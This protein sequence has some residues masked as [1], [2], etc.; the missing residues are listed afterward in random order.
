VIARI[1]AGGV[2]L[3]LRTVLEEQETEVEEALVAAARAAE[4]GG[5]EP[6]APPSRQAPRR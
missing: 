1:E 6:P 2:L 4:A 5:A 3:D